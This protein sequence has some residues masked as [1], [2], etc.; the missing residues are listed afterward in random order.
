MSLPIGIVHMVH[1]ESIQTPSL[2][3]H[4]MLQH[5]DKIIYKKMFSLSLNLVPHNKVKT[6]F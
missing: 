3:S 5:F 6:E 4:F 2:F 1:S